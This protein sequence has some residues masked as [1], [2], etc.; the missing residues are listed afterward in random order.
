[1]FNRYTFFLLAIPISPIRPE[2]NNQTAAGANVSATVSG[3]TIG[4]NG[5]TAVSG[6]R[7]SV[8]GNT[9]R[10]TSVVNRSSNLISKAAQ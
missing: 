7:M 3:S 10:A 9:I 5:V 2:P 1:M 8:S 4:I 6:S